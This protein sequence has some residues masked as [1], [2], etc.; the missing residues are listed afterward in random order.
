MGASQ[1]K[2]EK[3]LDMRSRR[4]DAIEERLEQEMR[5][6]EQS[7]SNLHNMMINVGVGGKKDSAR[8]EEGLADMVKQVEVIGGGRRREEVPGQRPGRSDA[9][10]VDTSARHLDHE[11][12]AGPLRA[13]KRCGHPRPTSSAR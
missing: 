13:R 5:K 12:L 7:M 8:L 10:G 4:M 2:V 11:L 6:A 1:G 3:L 9:D